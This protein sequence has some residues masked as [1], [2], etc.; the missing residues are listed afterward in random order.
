MITGCTLLS[1]PALTCLIRGV[2]HGYR[3]HLPIR[4]SLDLSHQMRQTWLVPAMTGCTL[5]SVPA[6]TSLIRGV[7]HG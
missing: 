1:D 4:S 5:V 7:K 6:L 3:V 2:K